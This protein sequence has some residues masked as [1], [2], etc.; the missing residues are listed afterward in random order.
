MEWVFIV[1]SVALIEYIFF[2]IQVGRARAKFEVPA[3][4]TTGHP[5]FERYFRVQQNTAE[6]LLVFIPAL[7]IYAYVGN[8]IYAAIA[9]V[10]FIIGRAIYFVSYVKDPKSRSAGFGITFLANAYML[11]AI[12]YLSIES[13]V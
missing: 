4:A 1:L 7:L 3:P 13:L 10:V 8:P 2:G 6:Q 9:G 5:E 12:L 11:V